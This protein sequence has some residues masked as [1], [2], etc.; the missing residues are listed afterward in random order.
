M[1]NREII[2]IEEITSSNQSPQT[3]QTV[4]TQDLGPTQPSRNLIVSAGAA[5][6]ILSLLVGVILYIVLT[7]RTSEE[8]GTLA[9]GTT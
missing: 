3:V 9:Y 4:T 1:A 8:T 6:T 7:L 2:G 5:V